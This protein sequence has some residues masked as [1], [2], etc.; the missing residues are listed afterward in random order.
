MHIPPP[1]P[2]TYLFPSFYLHVTSSS[3]LLVSLCLSLL[4]IWPW[5]RTKEP[6]KPGEEV[7]LL[8]VAIDIR[9]EREQIAAT[10]CTPVYRCKILVLGWN[11]G[12]NTGTVIRTGTQPYSRA[13][14]LGLIP[15]FPVGLFPWSNHTSDF[16]FGSTEATLPGAWHYNISAGTGRSCV[17][18][19][20]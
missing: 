2:R 13:A 4:P 8:T 20:W 17:S 3:Y 19:L 6:S 11:T 9:R 1:P 14:G 15:T 16:K 18:I 10:L 5:Q 7:K 12:K